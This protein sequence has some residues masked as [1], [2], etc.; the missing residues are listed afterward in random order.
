MR[1]QDVVDATYRNQDKWN[2]MAILCVA[3]SGFFSSD[4]TIQQYCD[5]I[6]KI[7]AVSIP[8]PS[9]DPKARVRSFANLPTV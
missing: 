7:P 2:E 8:H 4:R 1:A 6:W 3:R 5:E 9:Q